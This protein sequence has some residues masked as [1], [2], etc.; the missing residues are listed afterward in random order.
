MAL[1][2]CFSHRRALLAA[3]EN[4]TVLIK[5]SVTYPKFNIHKSVF[6]SVRQLRKVCLSVLYMQTCCFIVCHYIKFKSS[7]HLQKKHTATY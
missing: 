4:F 2:C 6:Y 3:A 5:N 7:F 1:T